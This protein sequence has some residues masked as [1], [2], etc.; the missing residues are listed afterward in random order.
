[1]AHAEPSIPFFVP[2]DARPLTQEECLVVR[3]LLRDQ[4][5]EYISQL[6]G[7]TVVGRCGCGECPTIFFQAH[8]H[9][10]KERDLV[11][12]IGKDADDGLVGAVLLVKD[13]L[14]SQL[15]FFSIDGHEPWSAPRPESLERCRS[16]G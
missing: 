2:T 12:C 14:L 7:L 11:S 6:D 16:H 8:A 1:M 10:D 4:G 5:L 13:G 15:E 9:G 3:R